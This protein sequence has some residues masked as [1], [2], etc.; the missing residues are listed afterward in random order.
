MTTPPVS[1]VPQTPGNKDP[2]YGK[3]LEQL[4]ASLV[5]HLDKAFDLK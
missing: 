1:G 3:K 5:K 2:E 4:R